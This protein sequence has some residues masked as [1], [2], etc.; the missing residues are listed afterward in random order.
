MKNYNANAK[1]AMEAIS[2]SNQHPAAQETGITLNHYEIRLYGHCSNCQHPK[3]IPS[4]QS[5]EFLT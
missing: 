5:E 3:E 4:I 1:A 2:A